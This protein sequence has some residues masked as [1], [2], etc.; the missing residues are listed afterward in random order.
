MSL[1]VIILSIKSSRIR[2]NI[3]QKLL[4]LLRGNVCLHWPPYPQ[5]AN[6]SF[7]KYL[8]HT[9]SIHAVTSYW[10]HPGYAFQ[11]MQSSKITYKFWICI[12][13]FLTKEFNSGDIVFTTFWKLTTSHGSYG[14]YVIR[15]VW[16]S[17]TILENVERF[18][19]YDVFH[20]LSCWC[21]YK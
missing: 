1:L 13:I 4:W 15:F 7:T 9:S 18:I 17:I 20:F 21:F 6:F 5:Q 14:K 16:R 3:I 2:I 12:G 11:I 19:L 8:L 10:W